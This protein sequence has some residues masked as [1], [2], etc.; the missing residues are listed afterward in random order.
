MRSRPI[1]SSRRLRDKVALILDDGQCKFGQPSSVVRVQDNHWQLLR[2]GVLNES[3]LKRLASF[4]L[5]FVCTGNTCR[6]P[7]ATLLMQHALGSTTGCRS[8][9]TGRSRPAG[10]VGRDRGDERRACESRS[11]PS[12]V[13]TRAGPQPAREPA[14][15]RS[16]GAICRSDPYNDSRAS[17][18]HP[19]PVAKCHAANARA[20][21][22]GRRCVR[23]DRRNRG[24]RIAT[25]PSKLT[26]FLKP[27]L[28]QLQLDQIMATG[29]AGG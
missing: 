17:G 9:G 25:V 13:G 1:R 21:W 19:G 11:C 28:D 10:H 26:T 22:I 15:E 12:A 4:I 27:W 2:E 7:M 23:S 6:S 14:L 5:L 3:T 8:G 18:G 20:G 24:S 29:G 16:P